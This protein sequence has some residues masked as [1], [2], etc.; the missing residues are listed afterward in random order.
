M[1]KIDIQE[2]DCMIHKT[3]QDIKKSH[4]NTIISSDFIEKYPSQYQRLLEKQA[5]Y[6]SKGWVW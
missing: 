3:Y 4:Q 6:L 5:D 2:R 1:M